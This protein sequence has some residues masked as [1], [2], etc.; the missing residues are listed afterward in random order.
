MYLPSAAVIVVLLLAV[1]HVQVERQMNILRVQEAGQ[2]QVAAQFLSHDM[3]SVTS[4]LLV[5]AH[6]PAMSIFL[7]NG[8]ELNRARLTELFRHVSDEK[9]LYDQIRFIDADG[10]ERIRINYSR[11]GA[12]T[13]SDADLQAKGERYYFQDSLRLAE[14]EIYVS[15]LDL[16][17]EHTQIE[18]PFKPM[19]RLGTPVFDKAGVKRGVV[20]LNV[21]GNQL[22]SDFRRAMGEKRHAMLPNR[23]GYW[24]SHPDPSRE[25]GFMFDREINLAVNEPETWQRLLA[26]AE[27]SF[28]TKA[29]LFT[30][31]TVYPLLAYQHSS[32]GSPHVNG[33][34][35]QPLE[36]QEYFWKVVSLVPADELPSGTWLKYHNY[37][38]ELMVIL[39]L[40]GVLVGYLTAVLLSRR[41]WQKAVFEN[42]NRLR[43]ITATLSEG[44]YVLD[45]MGLVTF[46]NPEAE[47]L[48]GWSEAELIGKNGHDTFH[49][50]TPEGKP[51]STE[52]C[53]VHRT[54][55]TGK[56]YHALNDWLIRKDGSLLPVSIVSTAILREDDVVGSVAAFQDITPRLEAERSLREAEAL[57]R[58]ALENAPIGMAI[59]SLDGHFTKVNRVLCRIVGYDMLELETLTFAAITHPDDLNADLNNVQRLL[60]GEIDDYQM[61]KRYIRKDGEMVWVQLTASLMRDADREPLYFLAQIEDITER[62]R[63][64]EQ[65]RLLAFYDILTGLPNRRLFLDH[66]DHVLTQ[67]KRYQRSLALM[68]LDLDHF[69]Q[70]ND[71]LGHDAGD[72]LLQEVAARLTASV[73]HGDTVSR[74]GGDEFVIVLTEITHP[75]DAAQVAEKILDAL[76]KPIMIHEHEVNV[77]ASIGIAIYPVDGTDDIQDLMKKADSAMYSAKESGRNQYCFSSQANELVD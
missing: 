33:S 37:L 59:V 31:T 28:S 15:P 70:V 76:H 4:D 26:D 50:H 71:T 29:G 65:I 16:N 56:V 22:L 17:I 55:K 9:R 58:S 24:L 45:K 13:V 12:V 69:K 18:R 47:R 60:N 10:K 27:G 66:F 34:S 6:A 30:F 3:E 1:L 64:Q 2:V 42:E 14:G 57:F 23:D 40:L 46:I 19:L 25:W 72:E 53:P 43:E 68:F 7:E 32:T 39:L 63:H 49:Y 54:I 73:R 74:Q 61:E 20:I 52:D 36:A 77:G 51:L 11:E 5:L 62:K 35:V 38:A 67:A 75:E 44:V 21:F 41:Q 8:N 48:I